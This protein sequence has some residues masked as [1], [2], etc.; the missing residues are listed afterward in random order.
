[1][2]R[3]VV[4][5]TSE[6]MHHRLSD[7]ELPA[8]FA[9]CQ[10]ANKERQRLPAQCLGLGQVGESTASTQSASARKGEHN[11]H[12]VA[13]LSL[14]WLVNQASGHQKEKKTGG[15]GEERGGGNFL[16]TMNME[17]AHA[18]DCQTSNYNIQGAAQRPYEAKEMA[19]S[20]SACWT[21]RGL[22]FSS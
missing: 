4:C 12:S 21:S 13:S 5:I 18:S 14:T 16:R 9:L 7:P 1:M 15:G 6:Q 2:S 17:R 19:H 22:G 3:C 8:L 11:L 10:E 20:K